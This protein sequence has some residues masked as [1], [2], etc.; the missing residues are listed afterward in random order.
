MNRLYFLSARSRPH[1]RHEEMFLTIKFQPNPN[2]RAAR[3]VYRV[4]R[5]SGWGAERARWMIY[6]LVSIRAERG[7][8]GYGL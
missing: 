3:R 2:I 1:H 4:L 8:K 7:G 6:D 5:K